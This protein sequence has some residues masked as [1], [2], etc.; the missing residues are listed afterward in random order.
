MASPD[1]GGG[2][3]PAAL[4]LSSP[5]G[6]SLERLPNELLQPIAE[7]LVPACSLTTRFALRAS[8]TWE[9]RDAGHQWADWLACHS[10]LLSFAQTSHRM[11]AIARPLLYHT[12]AIPTAGALV[13]LFRR[14]NERPEVRPWIRNIA[15]LL[16]VAG[17]ATVRQVHAEWQRQTGGR[18]LVAAPNQGPSVC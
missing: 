16:N 5:L 18:V 7:G 6:G 3:P 1:P 15:C 11:A 14:M 2:P 8:G 17:A 10:D 9:F 4:Q 13:R 12:L